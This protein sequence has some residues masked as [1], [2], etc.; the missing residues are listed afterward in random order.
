MTTLNCCSINCVNN[1]HGMCKAHEVNI[2]GNDAHF[3]SETECQGFNNSKLRATL[4]MFDNM[5]IVSRLQDYTSS[6]PT[7]SVHCSANNCYFNKNGNCTA[8]HVNFKT[9]DVNHK[10]CCNSFTEAY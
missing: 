7:T 6:A 8:E 5:N 4:N 3:V 1:K 9:N 10:T 2:S